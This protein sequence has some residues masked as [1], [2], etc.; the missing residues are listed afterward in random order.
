M[1]PRPPR[2]SAL[3]PHLP[4]LFSSPVTLSRFH[5]R[6]LTLRGPA[7]IL[8][9]LSSHHTP[10]LLVL[11]K[12]NLPVPVSSRHLTISGL[13]ISFRDAAARN[14]FLKAARH[15]I[16][17]L[18]DG[19]RKYEVLS[20]IGKGAAGKV[21]VVRRRSDGEVFAM[22]TIPKREALKDRSSLQGVVGERV[23][24]GRMSAAGCGCTVRLEDCFEANGYL[25]FV[26]EL[27]EYGDLMRVMR[28]VGKGLEE[29][30]ARAMFAE[31]VLGV[32]K[33]HAEGWL[34]RDVKMG[35]LLVD[36]AGHIR[37]AD[38]GLVKRVALDD[39]SVGRALSLV[40]TRRYMAPE[41]VKGGG[42]GVEGYGAEADVWSMGVVLYAMVCG[43]WPSWIGGE[44]AFPEGIG[45]E[46]RDLIGGMLKR[47]W[48]KRLGVKEVKEHVWMRSVDWSR[49]TY[50]A[51]EGVERTLVVEALRAQGVRRIWG[52]EG[53]DE[54]MGL[55]QQTWAM[56]DEGERRYGGKPAWGPG[57]V[58]LVGFEYM[59][60]KVDSDS[61]E[62]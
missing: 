51:E 60:W 15:A 31:V 45:A 9:K 39:G 52:E 25:C 44:V 27:A 8:S 48:T 22:K 23:L 6:L 42:E 50:E 28:T 41:V 32:E 24:L 34:V 43:V 53:E 11:S 55:K 40:G 18:S 7:V 49:V 2:S 12:S 4:L 21:Y 62:V 16:A 46:V 30:V 36:G 17:N 61:I 13:R 10:T 1:P 14:T 47:E 29:D 26:M 37:V 56:E 57:D 35:N 19:L 3:L 5:S 33:C 54:G 38:F 20:N 58:Q 59:D